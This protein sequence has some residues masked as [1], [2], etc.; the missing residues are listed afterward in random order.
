[1]IINCHAHH[2]AAPK[3]FRDKQPAAHPEGGIYRRAGS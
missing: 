3:A 1:M 2:T